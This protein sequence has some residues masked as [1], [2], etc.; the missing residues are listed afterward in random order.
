MNQRYNRFS[1]CR[2]HDKCIVVYSL[3]TNDTQGKSHR[4][5][6]SKHVDNLPAKC[7]DEPFCKG[8]QSQSFEPS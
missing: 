2:D 3:S 6:L 5:N 4:H 7:Y 8:H 1:L